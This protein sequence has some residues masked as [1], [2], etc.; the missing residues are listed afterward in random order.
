[1]ASHFA[2]D[3]RTANIT[4]RVVETNGSCFRI[5]DNGRKVHFQAEHKFNPINSQ[6]EWDSG[7]C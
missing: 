2:R 7:S 5:Y 4:D 6:W 3:V 1:M